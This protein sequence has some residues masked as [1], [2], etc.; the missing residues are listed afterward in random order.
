MPNSLAISLVDKERFG[1]PA[2]RINARNPK[3]VNTV[4]RTT[5]LAISHLHKQSNR[6]KWHPQYQFTHRMCAFWSSVSLMTGSYHGNPMLMHVPLPV[7]AAHFDR[8]LAL[9]EETCGEIC[10]PPAAEHF[11][12]R[13]RRIAQSLELGIAAS[14][15]QVLGQCERLQKADGANLMVVASDERSRRA[16]GIS[17][18]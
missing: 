8:W 2:S 3:S 17:N 6:I 7:D 11:I 18:R 5:D 14:R 13:A 16:P 15:G 10:P 12:E 1:S 9:F 4:R